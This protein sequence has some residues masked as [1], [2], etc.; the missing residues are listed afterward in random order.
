LKYIWKLPSLSDKG[1][2]SWPGVVFAVKK[3]NNGINEQD[4]GER[5]KRWPSRSLR[6]ISSCHAAPD[7]GSPHRKPSAEGDGGMR[8]G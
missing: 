7:R 2:A 5:G 1:T 8:R 6:G 3:D 4:W